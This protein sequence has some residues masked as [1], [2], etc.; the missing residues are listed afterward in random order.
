M[1]NCT[2]SSPESSLGP[3]QTFRR[4]VGEGR[5]A[6]FVKDFPS[7]T[8]RPGWVLTREG[9]SEDTVYA[10]IRGVVGVEQRGGREQD[11]EQLIAFRRDGDLIG[12]VAAAELTARTATVKARTE[13]EVAVIPGVRFRSA[14]FQREWGAA[15]LAYVSGRG[16]EGAMLLR[17]GDHLARVAHLVV[18]L[19]D[20][21]EKAVR[22]GG[23]VSLRVAQQ[24]VA[25]CLGLGRDTVRRLTS[26]A[27]FGGWPKGR[28]GSLLITDPVALRRTA[29]RLAG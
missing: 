12:D 7:L 28:G 9:W 11:V 16:R 18:P 27:P 22:P 5:W 4:R 23:M 26:A 20:D 10:L 14:E 24:E 19:L 21:A 13:C 25:D 15:L 8:R 2:V 17:S 1:T 3:H 6:C 29:A